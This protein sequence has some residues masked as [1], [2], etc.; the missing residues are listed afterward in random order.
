MSLQIDPDLSSEQ[1]DDEYL[2]RRGYILRDLTSS[3]FSNLD[4][5]NPTSTGKII[6]YT[7]D[8]LCSG[9]IQAWQKMCWSY[10]FDCI[11]IANPRIFPYLQKSFRR[12]NTYY[13]KYPLDMFCTTPEIQKQSVEVVLTLQGC[14]RRSRI[15]LPTIP[16]ITHDNADWLKSNVRS[17][18]ALP[19]V[20]VRKVW[21][22]TQDTGQALYGA[23]EMTYACLEG[24]TERA[25]FWMKWLIEED[26]L[27]KKKYGT[28]I[29]QLERGPS[30]LPSKQRA[31]IGFYICAILVE[32]YK[33]IHERGILK[34]NEEFQTIVDIYYGAD[35]CINSRIKT[36][37]IILMIEIMSDVPKWKLSSSPQLVK[38]P[39][40]VSRMS[41]NSRSF[42]T[43][44]LSLPNPRKPIPLSAATTVKKG[45]ISKNKSTKEEQLELAD[46][47]ISNFYNI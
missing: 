2:S 9:G 35:P 30:H 11:G 26:R 36:I 37:C 33:N 23:N 14:S 39:D 27:H 17:L 20:P 7:A 13:A 32:I 15:K 22:N 6:H 41:S 16:Q 38:N 47:L 43:E 24:N 3:F 12:L 5:C 34:M 19:P 25:L 46:K 18:S 4:E 21:N 8:L 42:F 31:S 40:L 44:I 45:K 10:A 1:Q 28:N 29:V